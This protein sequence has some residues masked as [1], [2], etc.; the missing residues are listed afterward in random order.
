MKIGTIH[1][2]SGFLKEHR[3]LSPAIKKKL[4]TKMLLFQENPLHPSLRLHK[5]SGKFEGR[6]SISITMQFRVIFRQLENSDIL[7]V[8]I[9][10]HAIYE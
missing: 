10:T 3:N 5:L 1:T 8:S 9:G 6:W 4:A 2:S 7:F